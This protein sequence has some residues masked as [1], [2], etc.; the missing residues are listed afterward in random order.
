MAATLAA[1]GG[2]TWTKGESPLLGRITRRGWP[3]LG[4][5][6]RALLLGL[7]P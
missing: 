2:E 1:F 4:Y 3:S 6:L 7:S 5:L